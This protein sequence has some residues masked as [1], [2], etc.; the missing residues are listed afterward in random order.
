MIPPI[1]KVSPRVYERAAEIADESDDPPSCAISTALRQLY[2]HVPVQD[3]VDHIT[4]FS[5]YFNTAFSG[6]QWWGGKNK[7]VIALLLMA[8]LVEDEQAK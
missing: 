3:A 6:R 1:L 5:D 7:K 2:G 8:H 4:V